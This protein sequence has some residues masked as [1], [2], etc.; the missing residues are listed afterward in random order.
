LGGDDSHAPFER[1]VVDQ[2]R[3]TDRFLPAEGGTRESL[4]LAAEAAADPAGHAVLT[5]TAPSGAVL[6]VSREVVQPTADGSRSTTTDLRMSTTVKGPF[7]WHVTPSVRPL[8]DGGSVEE[9][10]RLDCAR[11]DGTVLQSVEVTGVRGQTAAV[12]L[13]GC[14]TRWTG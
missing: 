14:V 6:T 4:L 7:E 3:G 2:Y 11:P 9:R 8:H 1:G 5:G 13:G 12:D 10:W